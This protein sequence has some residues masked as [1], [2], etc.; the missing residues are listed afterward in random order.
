[1]SLLIRRL[2]FALQR[3]L[4][5]DQP[6]N[7]L[8][9][10]DIEGDVSHFC[11]PRNCLNRHISFQEREP[12]NLQ[13]KQHN[14]D[15]IQPNR[16]TFNDSLIIYFD[17][18]L[19]MIPNQDHVRRNSVSYSLND[20]HYE[21]G[22]PFFGYSISIAKEESDYDKLYVYYDIRD[23]SNMYSLSDPDM[24][25]R[26]TSLFWYTKSYLSNSCLWY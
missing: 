4:A 16:T 7:N 19:T 6:V 15:S 22:Y 17:A 23:E 18:E 11:D 9:N 25:P 14:F 20:E 5:R 12:T 2:S 8:W 13:E 1:M 26:K 10:Q 24:S 21:E 3:F